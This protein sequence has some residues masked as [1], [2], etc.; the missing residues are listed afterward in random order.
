MSL[1]YKNPPV[2]LPFLTKN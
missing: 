1:T 2:N